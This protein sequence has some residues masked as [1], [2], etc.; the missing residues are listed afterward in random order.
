MENNVIGK[1]SILRNMVVCV[2]IM[3]LVV[4][5]GCGKES[6][7]GQEGSIDDPSS[8]YKN[9]ETI[10]IINNHGKVSN[11]EKLDDF[12]EGLS[13][14][15]RIVSYTTEG[16]PIYSELVR[17]NDKIELRY[18]TT[19]DKFGTPKVYTYMCEKLQKKET[20]ILLSYTLIGCDGD[21]KQMNVLSITYDA[22]A[23]DVFEFAVQYG[24][25]QKNEIDTFNQK[26]VK[27]LQNGTAAE[28]SDFQFTMEE[29]G[30]IYK[31][32]VLANYLTEKK[33]STACNKKPHISYHMKVQINGG[34]IDYDWAE[35]DKSKDGQ[36]MTEVVN[37]IIA[38]VQAKEEYK[39]L[40][41]IKSAYM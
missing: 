11:Y 19:K 31:K 36:L 20:D 23:Q 27:D 21:E 38:I 16:D 2:F 18:D 5:A 40:P 15:Q 14:K 9:N 22:E 17:K 13:D 32:L 24:V 25:N 26:L 34:S 41:A 10:D 8:M 4:L 30:L 7:A 28:V 39:T 3:L 37:E 1:S 35:C 6:S 33:L 12:V 29:R